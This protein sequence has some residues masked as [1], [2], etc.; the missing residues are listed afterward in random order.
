MTLL[1]QSQTARNW[2]E[3]VSVPR[4]SILY[5]LTKSFYVSRVVRGFFHEK[6]SEISAG[7]GWLGSIRVHEFLVLF[8]TILSSNYLSK[9]I[10]SRDL[11]MFYPIFQDHFFAIK[12]FFF[13]KICFV[14]KNR[15]W[16]RIN[17]ECRKM[18][19]SRTL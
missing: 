11:Y 10:M 3:W 17:K 8:K 5:G 15:L 19:V 16:R 13:I 6:W 18:F 4:C 14:I 2:V 12:N 9:A 7:L 1:R